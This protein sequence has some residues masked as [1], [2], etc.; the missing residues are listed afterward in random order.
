M[1]IL[2]SKGYQWQQTSNIIV[3]PILITKKQKIMPTYLIE[4]LPEYHFVVVDTS[5]NIVHG[6]KVNAVKSDDEIAIIRK[7]GEGLEI[8]SNNS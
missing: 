4:D 8:M 2:N 6:I 3:Q 1:P 5:G 7:I